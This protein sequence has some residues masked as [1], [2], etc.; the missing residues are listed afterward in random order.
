[1]E[2]ENHV[3]SPFVRIFARQYSNLE[4]QFDEY[5]Q[6]EIQLHQRGDPAELERQFLETLRTDFLESNK[7]V[8]DTF[9]SGEAQ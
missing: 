9:F 2:D 3:P 5:Y 6:N 1:M 4:Q 7:K 8:I